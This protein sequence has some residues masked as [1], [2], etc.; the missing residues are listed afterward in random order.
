MIWVIYLD[1][2]KDLYIEILMI[3]SIEYLEDLTSNGNI[4]GVFDGISPGQ[5]PV[6]VLKY[7]VG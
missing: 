7:S 1:S 3:N 4:D 2:M 5:E 6:I